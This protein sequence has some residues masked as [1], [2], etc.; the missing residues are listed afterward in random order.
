MQGERK[1]KSISQEGKAVG[2]CTLLQR[3]SSTVGTGAEVSTE[4]R[5]G[6]M[7]SA[8]PDER[9]TSGHMWKSVFDRLFM[10]VLL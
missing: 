10:L 2:A 8:L 5:S 9:L 6:R 3:D 1:N 7:P 4:P